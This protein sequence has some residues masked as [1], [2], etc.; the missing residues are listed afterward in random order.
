[1]SMNAGVGPMLDLSLHVAAERLELDIFNR[2][3]NVI[4]NPIIR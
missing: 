2:I 1:M 4:G 3:S